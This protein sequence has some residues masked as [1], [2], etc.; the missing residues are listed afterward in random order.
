MSVVADVVLDSERPSLLARYWAEA[1]DGYEVAPYDE[2]E[3]ERLRGSASTAP[4]TIRPF[5]SWGPPDHRG[6]SSFGSRK[7]TSCSA[8]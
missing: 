2:D 4:R 5:S 7:A 1:L 3:P 6:S 8:C